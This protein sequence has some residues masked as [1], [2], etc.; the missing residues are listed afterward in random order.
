MQHLLQ[1]IYHAVL[2]RIFW[3]SVAPYFLVRCCSIFLVWCC[4]SHR[5]FCVIPG[6]KEIRNK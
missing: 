1:Q 2:Y 4:M 3:R 5:V 6:M